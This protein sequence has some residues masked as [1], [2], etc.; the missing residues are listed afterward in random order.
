MCVNRPAG[1]RQLRPA[2]L[3]T[4]TILRPDAVRFYNVGCQQAH[5][6]DGWLLIA[7]KPNDVR[8]VNTLV[9]RCIV[10]V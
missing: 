1:S 2:G 7:P 6:L 5:P 8:N 3:P 10:G 9:A 4:D